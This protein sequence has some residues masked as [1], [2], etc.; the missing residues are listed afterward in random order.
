MPRDRYWKFLM[1]LQSLITGVCVRECMREC[2]SVCV[3]ECLSIINLVS[4]AGVR[5]CVDVRNSARSEQSKTVVSFCHSCHQLEHAFHTRPPRVQ[6]MRLG[7]P[8]S[9]LEHRG[10][11]AGGARSHAQQSAAAAQKTTTTNITAAGTSAAGAAGAV[12]DRGNSSGGA[13]AKALAVGGSGNVNGTSSGSGTG[14]GTFV[15][16]NVGER[17]SRPDIL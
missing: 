8:M 12:G 14:G 6:F 2:A 1:V 15:A 16:V 7:P 5:V 17:S 13:E 3:C 4:I 10:G 11:G 9:S